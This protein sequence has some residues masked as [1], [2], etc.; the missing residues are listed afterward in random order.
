MKVYIVSYDS[1]ELG[2]D[3]VGFTNLKKAKTF[4]SKLK[5]SERKK[6]LSFTEEPTIVQK[7]IPISKEGIITAINYI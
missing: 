4:V 1:P 7:K 3:V 5:R 6:E 2:Y